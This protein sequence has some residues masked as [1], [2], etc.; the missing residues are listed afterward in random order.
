MISQRPVISDFAKEFNFDDIRPYYDHEVKPMLQRII[1]D[2]VFMQLVN[3]LWP[4]MTF[5]QVFEKC[6]NINSSLEFQLEFM[7]DAIHR[8]VE[9][10]SSG[11]SSSGFQDLD[12]SK[13]YLFIANHRD[14]LLDAAI[15]QILLVKHGFP[16]SEISFGSNL[17][18]KGFV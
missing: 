5:E 18:E 9:L 16:T 7:N 3:Y 8:I 2:P 10:S 13:T 1:K 11:L 14:I 12:P 6:K 17:K 15:L 4:G